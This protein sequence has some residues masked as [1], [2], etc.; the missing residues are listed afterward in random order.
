MQMVYVSC[1]LR[2]GGTSV[3]KCL[4]LLGGGLGGCR[5]ITPAL[6]KLILGDLKRQDSVVCL[7]KRFQV[8]HRSGEEGDGG[9]LIGSNSSPT[10]DQ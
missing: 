7:R 9:N 10:F 8:Q 5:N 3:R 6:G 1:Q 4:F 2:D